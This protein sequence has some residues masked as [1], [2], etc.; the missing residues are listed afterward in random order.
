MPA[1]DDD[2]YYSIRHEVSVERLR[3]MLND[4]RLKTRRRRKPQ[5]PRQS[6]PGG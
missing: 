4:P 1:P 3:V 6:S 2:M 5:S